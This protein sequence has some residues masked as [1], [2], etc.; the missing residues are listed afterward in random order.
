MRIISKR[1]IHTLANFVA[2]SQCWLRKTNTAINYIIIYYYFI[3]LYTAGEN[4]IATT[5]IRNNYV[6][7]Q[8]FI[9]PILLLVKLSLLILFAS[10]WYQ[11]FASFLMAS[12]L[13]LSSNLR[14]SDNCRS[15]SLLKAIAIRLPLLFVTA[16]KS[17][18]ERHLLLSL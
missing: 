9:F 1:P 18:K 14:D 11:F 10:F 2:K 7:I 13:K 4:I 8:S 16:F 17:V 12:F 5:K 6:A 3:N 15:F